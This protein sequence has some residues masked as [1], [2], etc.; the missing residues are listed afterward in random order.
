MR[1]PSSFDDLEDALQTTAKQYRRNLWRNAN[2][3]L[4]IWLEKDVLAGVIYPVTS[5]YDVPLMV[6]KGFSSE[7]FTY[8]AIAACF[9]GEHPHTDRPNLTAGDCAHAEIGRCLGAA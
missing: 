9:P 4:E 3:Y 5:I 1:K 8:K 2:H 6:T 7:T